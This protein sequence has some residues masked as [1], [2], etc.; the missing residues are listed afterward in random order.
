[1]AEYYAVLRRA[2]AGLGNN[3]AE[4]RRAVYDKARN[5]LIGQLKAI[6]P[7]LPTSEISRQR[8]ELEE[9]IRKVERESAQA[10]PAPPRPAQTISPSPQPAPAP[11]PPPAPVSTAVDQSPPAEAVEGV[12]G[13]CIALTPEVH[14]FGPAG[15]WGNCGDSLTRPPRQTVRRRVTCLDV[16]VQKQWLSSLRSLLWSP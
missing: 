10:P 12:T 15:E 9:A 14:A 4:S 5:A 11:P 3:T 2:V 8:L 16:G 7:P 1:M 6:D 13:E